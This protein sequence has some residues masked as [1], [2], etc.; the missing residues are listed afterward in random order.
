[1]ELSE[2]YPSLDRAAG[3]KLEDDY[4][5]LVA[6]D[7]SQRLPGQWPRRGIPGKRVMTRACQSSW[8]MRC[9]G[10]EL[11]VEG[12]DLRGVLTSLV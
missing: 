6:R 7:F 8:T 4:R 9:V 11:S 1:M 10:Y 3:V 5:H 12:R 2:G